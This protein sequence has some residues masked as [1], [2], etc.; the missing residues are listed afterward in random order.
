MTGVAGCASD[1]GFG[2]G[3]EEVPDREDQNTIAVRI[4]TCVIGSA[5]LRS[6]VHV[7]SHRCSVRLD[8][9]GAEVFMLKV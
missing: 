4:Y 9:I 7:G 1:G 8:G 6:S 5:V 3:G 2:P